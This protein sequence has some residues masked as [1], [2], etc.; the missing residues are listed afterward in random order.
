MVVYLSQL[1]MSG[2]L[3]AC[4]VTLQIMTEASR[5]ENKLPAHFAALDATPPAPPSI[6]QLHSQHSH[7]AHSHETRFHLPCDEVPSLRDT[8]PA[9][10]NL[11]CI[12]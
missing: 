5:G 6:T 10:S 4:E 1:H 12:W 3:V 9:P 7:I 8:P 11:P 2:N